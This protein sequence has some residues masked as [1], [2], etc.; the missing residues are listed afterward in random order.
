M[1]R[2]IVGVFHE[3]DSTTDTI[4]ELKHKNLGKLTA[5]SPTLRH[6]LEEAIDPP[7]SHV[8]KFTLFGALAG[9]SFGYWLSIWGSNYWPLVVGGKAISTWLRTRCSAS[10]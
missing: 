5:Y 9:V 3:L 4:E 8:R 2:G 7:Q 10:R 1:F 6:E